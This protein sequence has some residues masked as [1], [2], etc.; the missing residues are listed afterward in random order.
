MSA[1]GDDELGL[2]LNWVYDPYD[3]KLLSLVCKQWPSVEDLALLSLRVV[4]PDSL[5]GLLPS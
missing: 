4:E 5:R 2:I 1:L 3:R